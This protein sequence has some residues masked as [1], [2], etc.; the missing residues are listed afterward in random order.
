MVSY[1]TRLPLALE[2]LGSYLCG[3]NIEKL[4][5]SIDALD[6]DNIKDIFLD[7]AS[8]FIGMDRDYV[9]TIMVVV[10]SQKLELVF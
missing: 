10:S 8:F 7:I 2:V 1:A 6:D 5:I 4:R 3:R 9:I